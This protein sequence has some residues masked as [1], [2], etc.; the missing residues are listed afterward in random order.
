MI[1]SIGN[2]CRNPHMYID[3]IWMNVIAMSLSKP[4][5]KPAHT[6]IK[7]YSTIVVCPNTATM[8]S[9][10]ATIDHHGLSLHSGH[11]TA[12]INCCKKILLQRQ[13]NY[14]V[15][16]LSLIIDNKYSSTV[17]VILFEL[18]DLW[19]LDSNRWVGVWSH[20]LHPTNSTSRNK[21]RNPWV[22]RCVSSW[23]PLSP[24]RNSVL[25]Y[26]YLYV[27]VIRVLL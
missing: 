20:P 6:W 13:Q 27:C 5:L 4:I 24:S 8:V 2:R 16:L 11:H 14:G 26:I 7:T 15:W 19:V 12:S 18:I 25:I 3:E 22:G 17:F 23:C 10:R 1:G 21:R 9:L